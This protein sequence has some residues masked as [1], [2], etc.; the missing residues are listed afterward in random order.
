[1]RK[2]RIALG[3]L[4]LLAGIALVVVSLN[5]PEPKCGDQVMRPGDVCVVGN[6]AVPYAERKGGADKRLL[7]TGVGV[8][9]IGALLL[10]AGAAGR[11]RTGTAAPD[12]GA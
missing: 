1:V 6:R 12:T 8:G 5:P 3:V 7:G 10:V 9:L 4:L 2:L 11:R